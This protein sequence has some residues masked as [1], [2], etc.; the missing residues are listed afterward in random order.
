MPP[1]RKLIEAR[2]D[3]KS[4]LKTICNIITL[5]GYKTYSNHDRYLDEYLDAIV[6]LTESKKEMRAV[7]SQR[8]ADIADEEERNKSDVST[9]FHNLATHKTEKKYIVALSKVKE[10]DGSESGIIK[11]ISQLIALLKVYFL[12]SVSSSHTIINFADE[13]NSAT[14]DVSTYGDDHFK[15]STACLEEMVLKYEYRIKANKMEVKRRAL[16][17]EK[18]AWDAVDKYCTEAVQGGY[19]TS[20]EV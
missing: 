9:Y 3:F 4:Q 18:I 16:M 19:F 17:A 20:Q 15:I 7:A 8:L 1:K 10:H 5:N 12:A 14:K 2:E 6:C 11:Y 13:S